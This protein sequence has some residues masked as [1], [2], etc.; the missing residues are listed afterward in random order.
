MFDSPE[1][2]VCVPLFETAQLRGAKTWIFDLDNTLYPAADSLF[3]RMGARIRDYIADFL[4]TDSDTAHNLQKKYFRTY[5]TSLRGLMLEHGVDPVPFLDFVHNIDLSEIAP[6]PALDRA[7]ANLTGQKIIFTNADTGHAE[8]ILA[9]LG[10]AGHFHAIFDIT[11]A[12]YIPKP[13]PEPYDEIVRR[14]GLKPGTAVM[15]DDIARNLAPA[16]ARGITTVWLRN[17]TDWGRTGADGDHIHHTAEDLTV[18]L[19]GVGQG[20]SQA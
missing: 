14:H 18:W 6:N 17:D 9:R 1:S 19:E 11:D 15:V 2:N 8:R 12:E 10:I 7:L 13:D 20:D 5:G 4:G 16:A 3:L